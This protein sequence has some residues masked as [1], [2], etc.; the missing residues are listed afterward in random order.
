MAALLGKLVK[1]VIKRAAKS[2]A[3]RRKV[4]QAAQ[5]AR[6]VFNSS[7]K[8]AKQLC[9]KLGRQL[10]GKKTVNEVLKDARAGKVASSRQYTKPGG[11]KQANKDFD[12]LIEGPAKQYGQGVRVGK[13]S[14]GV[15]KVVVR[16]TSSGGKPT[17]EIQP[18]TG[19]VTKIRYD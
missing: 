11:L 8:Q 9:E 10:R 6:G 4:A 15:S 7:K 14:D 3:V 16:P 17:V 18:P 12:S 5:K 13:M 19:K 2:P 1:E